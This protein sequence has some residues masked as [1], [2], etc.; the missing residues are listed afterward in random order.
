M[1]LFLACGITLIGIFIKDG[2]KEF[3]KYLIGATIG[4]LVALGVAE[5]TTFYFGTPMLLLM[6]LRLLHLFQDRKGTP[7]TRDCIL[8]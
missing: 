2:Y 8:H 5:L 4:C 6:H 1:F 7:L 3:L